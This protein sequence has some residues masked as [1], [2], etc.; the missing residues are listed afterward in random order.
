[1]ILQYDIITFTVLT[2]PIILIIIALFFLIFF[3]N[4]YIKTK[5]KIFGYLSIFF[6]TF[7]LQNIF[8]EGEMLNPIID[9]KI[10]NYVMQQIFT[11]LVLYSMVVLLEVFESGR[12]ISRRQSIMSFLIFTTLGAILS[13]PTYTIDETQLSAVNY[14]EQELIGTFTLFFYIIAGI[15]LTSMLYRTYKTSWSDKQKKIIRLLSIGVFLGIFFPIIGIISILISASI[16]VYLMVITYIFTS[17][18]R[19]IGVFIIGFAFLRASKEPW[20]LQRQKVHLLMVYSKDGILL[21]SKIFNEQLS[22]ERTLLLAGGFSAIASLFK[23]ATAAT[24]NIKSILLE[25]KQLRIVNRKYFICTTLIESETQASEIAHNNFVNDF[26]N[27]FREQ[28][29]RFSG[30]ISQFSA[31]D[32]IAIKYFS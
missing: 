4:K 19:S 15:W 3:L 7:L 14:S 5:Y 17:V 31:A 24:G 22:E 25:D 32:E 20:L 16:S 26:E 23:E 29:A 11:L 12:G 9:V 30:E 2:I 27:M 21:Y 8:Q 1:M 18:I 6:F 10:V 28:L 13:T